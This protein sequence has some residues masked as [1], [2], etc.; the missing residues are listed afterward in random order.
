MTVVTITRHKDP[1]EGERVQ[2]LRRW[3]RKHGR[4]DLLVVLPNGRK[5]LIPQAW[6]DAEPAGDV[7]ADEDEPVATLATVA[8]LSAAVVIVAA[9][10]R[11]SGQEQAASQSTC[12]EE[13]DAAYPA[14]S[15]PR[16]VPAAT[17]GAAGPASRVR[18]G[19]SDPA[20]GTPDRHGVRRG[21]GARS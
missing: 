15:A 7:V 6:T 9:L 16:T 11:R 20:A 4:V 13:N 1:L 3:R 12:E 17:T 14:Q 2:V 5:R 10:S 19:R 8:D 21:R 18:R